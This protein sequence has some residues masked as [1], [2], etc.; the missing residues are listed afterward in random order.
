MEEYRFDGFRFDGVTSMMYFHHGLSFGFSGD[1]REYFGDHTDLTA[2]VYLMLANHMLH[3]LS[4]PAL[5]IAEDV[6]GMPTLVSVPVRVPVRVFCGRS[7]STAGR[8][9]E[10]VVHASFSTSSHRPTDSAS[11]PLVDAAVAAAVPPRVGGRRW[12]RLPAWYGHP[13]Q[14]D[15]VPEG[16]ER[17]SVTQACPGVALVQVAAKREV[18]RP[19]PCE[20]LDA[21]ATT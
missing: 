3:S 11:Y 9:G 14:V 12:L 19:S 16:E 17:R 8:G 13:R 1:Y 20:P 10:M 6:S 15:P 21:R 7:G 4:V 18:K 2:V 5:S